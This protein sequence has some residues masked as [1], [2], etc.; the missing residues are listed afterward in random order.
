[1]ESLFAISYVKDLF[2]TSVS[3]LLSRHEFVNQAQLPS[4][5]Y[6]SLARSSRCLVEG[7]ADPKE[8]VRHVIPSLES[9]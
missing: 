1:M 9:I 6:W 8:E 7:F 5:V 4:E 3:L 2:K